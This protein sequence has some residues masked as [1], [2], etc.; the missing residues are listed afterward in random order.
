MREDNPGAALEVWEDKPAN[1]PGGESAW[2]INLGAIT[3]SIKSKH[4]GA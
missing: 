1:A 2:N 4:Q 3:N